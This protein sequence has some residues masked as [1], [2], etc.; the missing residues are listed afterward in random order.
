MEGQ[1][2]DLSRRARPYGPYGQSS[3]RFRR[4]ATPEPWNEFYNRTLENATWRYDMELRWFGWRCMCVP[5]VCVGARAASGDER[6]RSSCATQTR[7]GDGVRHDFSWSRYYHARTAT[8]SATWSTDAH[9]QRVYTERDKIMSRP[10]ETYELLSSPRQ[11][12]CCHSPSLSSATTARR[13]SHSAAACC[14]A[15]TES[16]VRASS[17]STR[18]EKWEGASQTAGSR[19]VCGA[20]PY[21][22]REKSSHR[23]VAAS[24]RRHSRA[25]RSVPLVRP[26]TGRWR[27]GGSG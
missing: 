8:R 17:R 24:R 18:R 14:I 16:R 25:R 3:F 11:L 22:S 6:P 2:S 20:L 19:D 4:G 12:I 26:S 15:K 23:H 10:Q 7:M 9:E 27:A 5:Y 21:S 13:C 1:C